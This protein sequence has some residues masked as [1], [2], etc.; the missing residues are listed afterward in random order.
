MRSISILL[1]SKVIQTCFGGRTE[2]L[3]FELGKYFSQRSGQT[4]EEEEKV[5]VTR[6]LRFNWPHMKA[7]GSGG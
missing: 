5:G 3:Y 6:I 1:K 4:T 2:A 7:K